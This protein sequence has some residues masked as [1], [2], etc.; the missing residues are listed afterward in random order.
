MQSQDWSTA[1]TAFRQGLK[2]A[3]PGSLANRSLRHKLGTALYISGDPRAAIAE[4]R[5]LV[6]TPAPDGPDEWSATA[7][8]S[9]GVLMA[10]GG[11][12]PSAIAYLAQ[13]VAI[14]PDYA[15]AH[16]ALA[17]ALR[18]TQRFADA[19]RH[20]A[21]VSRIDPA[22]GD[23]RF[24]QA[25]ALVRLGRYAD[26]R[27]A[28]VIALTMQPDQ[29]ML[30]LALARVLA[31]A[32]DAKAR[33]GSRALALAQKVA[34]TTQDIE[35]GE[36]LAMAFAETGDYSRAVAVQQDVIAAA[37]DAG[38]T[39]A[40]AIMAG[41]LRLYQQRQPCRTPWDAR[42]PVN[43]PGPPVSPELAKVVRAAAQ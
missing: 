41:N 33:D 13:A 20:Y 7:S 12:F 14:E 10:S 34:A 16:M 6:R 25:I 42:D 5:E 28:L 35:V 38:L 40:V 17:D 15:E 4:F 3:R 36:T 8:Y 19:V 18:R 39:E 31:T 1:I 27:D 23:A 11:V 32:P 37:R 43:Q 2:V 21:E 26:A 30:T 22:N 24:G 29:P 9:L